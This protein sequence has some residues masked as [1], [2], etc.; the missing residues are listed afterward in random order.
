MVESRRRTHLLAQHPW[1]YPDS[2][3]VSLPHACGKLTDGLKEL[4]R[5]PQPHSAMKTQR[6][7]TA[8]AG[9]PCQKFQAVRSKRQMSQKGGRWLLPPTSLSLSRKNTTEAICRLRTNSFEGAYTRDTNFPDKFPE[10]HRREHFFPVLLPR[11]VW[12]TK[13]IQPDSLHTPSLHRET[14]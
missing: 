5:Q 14:K 4:R 9:T 11:I 1:N 12:L 7:S 3:L 8:A 2:D 6:L 10:G 13:Y